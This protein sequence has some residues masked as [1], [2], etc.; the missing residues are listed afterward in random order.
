MNI[1]KREATDH[2]LVCVHLYS[3]FIDE[4]IVREHLAKPA[5]FDDLLLY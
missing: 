2:L 1:I 4:C 5:F 3:S